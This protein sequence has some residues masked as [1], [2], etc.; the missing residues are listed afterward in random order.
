MAFIKAIDGGEPT[1]FN[2]RT[3][4]GHPLSN[5]TLQGQ[6]HQDLPLFQGHEAMQQGSKGKA[7]FRSLVMDIKREFRTGTWQGD[8]S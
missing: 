3:A 2:W 5:E 6:I 1:N 4:T 7:N 8:P